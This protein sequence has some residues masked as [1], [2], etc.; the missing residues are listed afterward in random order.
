VIRKRR[1][2]WLSLDDFLPGE[3]MAALEFRS[4][5]DRAMDSEREQTVQSLLKLLKPDERAIIV[6]RYWND[7]S[8]EEI[9]GMLRTN[10]GVVKSR[11]FRARQALANRIKVHEM[12]LVLSPA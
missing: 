10:V 12:G 9:A 6:L 2:N 3:L 4:V 1:M 5:E 11:L 7:L 8:Y